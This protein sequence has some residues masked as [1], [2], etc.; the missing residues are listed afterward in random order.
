DTDSE[1]QSVHVT[2]GGKSFQQKVASMRDIKI[3]AD[4]VMTVELSQGDNTVVVEKTSEDTGDIN[5]DC[6]TVRKVE[7]SY[8]GNVLDVK[9]DKTS[10]LTVV[11]DNA[12]V[13]ITSVGK[14]AVKVWADPTGKFERQYESFS[15]V[16]EKIDPQKLAVEKQGDNYRVNCG[17][18]TL[19][20]A[21]NA[22][23]SLT[24]L[25]SNGNVI[26]QNKE[27]S[28]GWTAEGELCV[29]SELKLGEQ[30]WGLGEKVS[31]FNHR[32]EKL[33]MWAVDAYGSECD[34]SCPAW[35]HGRWYMS[36]PYFVS[37]GGYSIFFDNSSRTVFDMG[38]TDPHC[39]SFG[40]SNPNPG[41]DLVY[42]FIYGPQPKQVTKTF[43]DL[44]GKTFFAPE[45]AYGNIQCHYGY[46]QNDVE[47]V[48]QK[49]REAGIPIDAIMCDIEWYEYLCT[50]TM[51]SKRNFPDPEGMIKRLQDA[52]IRLGVINDPNITNRDNNADFVAGDSQ[53]FF[54]KDKTGN[55]KLISWPWGADSGLV[56]FFNPEAREWWGT[57]LDNLLNQGVSCFWLDMNEPARYN[58]DWLFWNED[59]KAYGTLNQVKNA[60]AI[61]H[62]EAVHDRVTRNGNRSFLLTRSG[63][64]GTQRYASPWTGDIQAS[65]Q[66]MH[67][68]IML[69]TG[70]SMSGY[71]YWGFD[72]GG[73]FGNISN[74][75]YDRWVELA[76]FTPVH[77]FHYCAGVEE[78]EPYTHNA[79]ELSKK[80]IN[81]RYRLVPY[82]YSYAADNIIGIGIEEGY[83][84]G[85][86]GIP[87][88]RPMVM[89]FDSDEKTY[90][91]DTQ[92]M[93]GESF[94][95]APVLEDAVTKTV[96]LPK[97]VWY[98]YNDDKALYGGEKEMVYPAPYDVLP[99]FV[100]EG[101]VIPT[102]SE[103]QYMDD[104]SASPD[105]T[106][107]VF[108]TLE[109][110]TFNFVLYE[111][112]GMTESYKDG[113]YATTAFDASVE[114]ATI[115]TTTLVIGKRQGS[116]TDIAP[117]N[118]IV[119]FHKSAY[120][121]LAVTVDGK[122]CNWKLDEKKQI[123]TVNVAD[124]GAEHTVVLTGKSG[125][126]DLT[127][128]EAPVI[129]EEKTEYE[130]NTDGGEGNKVLKTEND[131]FKFAGLDVKHAGTYA[132]CLTYRS[133]KAAKVA[134]S[135]GNFTQ[136]IDLPA[137]VNPDF[138]NEVFVNI[139][140]KKGSNRFTVTK[141]D[142]EGEVTLVKMHA[143]FTPYTLA[144]TPMDVIEN[145][146]FNTGELNPWKVTALDGTEGG[147]GIDN[148]DA[149]SGTHKFY[150][151][152]CDKSLLRTLSQKVE[153]LPNGKYVV[154]AKCKVY[155]DSANE[156]RLD[157]T[158]AGVT[159]KKEIPRT[160]NWMTFTSDV[161]EVTDG[162]L[163]ISFFF[164]APTFSS[165]Q[166]DDVELYE[167]TK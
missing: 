89:E 77:R 139:P 8:V 98:D 49:Y 48:A 23:F 125:T 83:G 127:I 166:V 138:E 150:F 73:F 108:P 158:S 24:Y 96:Y 162:T 129:V 20:F 100:K 45:Y 67:E 33:E 36:N 52:H 50:P 130:V 120:E 81:M 57:L 14:N 165:L 128:L 152:D 46:L 147:Y 12:D 97:G 140:L 65:Y 137:A 141:L 1:P 26:L 99:V 117:R 144:T 35:D 161:V 102:Q 74:K 34:A 156:V 62:Q 124:D 148:F 18:I 42:Y 122:A 115:D 31:G 68:Q 55:T 86:T 6:I 2:V 16:N 92:F 112:D 32:G 91:C 10:E 15:V 85:G 47:R 59:G 132:A 142:G 131:S 5:V 160:E 17:D 60:Y 136:E 22:P 38:Y 106:V 40:S 88:V 93:C 119:K 30:F 54:V 84:Q 145:H 109:S 113:V 107:D 105:I 118:Y 79:T 56:D 11:C 43:T 143:P 41:G 87:L 126:N 116:F 76:T 29:N 121:D 155:N 104:P 13:K 95:V 94:L 78:K 64:T 164:D 3:W 21:K 134:I 4:S 159:V 103:R 51:W 101:S 123:V 58:T 9:G 37:S 39:V 80:F 154:K 70:L 61:K 82:M 90:S 28:M 110:G 53:R 44:V 146:G 151:W 71:N 157:L 66:S 72:I 149:Y 69:G 114:R 153:N 27:Q 133:D 63:Y 75:Q 25:D 167:V 163:D 135:T 7:W 111:D 19:V